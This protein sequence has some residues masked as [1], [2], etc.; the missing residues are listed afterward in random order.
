[1]NIC[2]QAVNTKGLS[3]GKRSIPYVVLAQASYRQLFHKF[4]A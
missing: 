2:F 4:G 3:Q 1:M